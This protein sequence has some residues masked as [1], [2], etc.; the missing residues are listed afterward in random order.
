MGT[1]EAI[2]TLPCTIRLKCLNI[3]KNISNILKF[4]ANRAIDTGESAW[5]HHCYE[6]TIKEFYSDASYRRLSDH[7]GLMRQEVART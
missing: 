6:N 1:T 2:P 7:A 4:F 5:Y 3:Y